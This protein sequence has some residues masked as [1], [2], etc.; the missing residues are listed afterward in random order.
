MLS[1]RKTDRIEKKKKIG[2]SPW[3]IYQLG[4]FLP[5]VADSLDGEQEE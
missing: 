4:S 3:G 5:A 1:R 2:R